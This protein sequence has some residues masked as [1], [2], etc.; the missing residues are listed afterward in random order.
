M[1]AFQEQVFNTKNYR[2][3]IVKDGTVDT[4]RRCNSASE[5]VQRIISGCLTLTQLDYRARHDS[6]AKILHEKLAL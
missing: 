6:V 3:F 2:T 4:C 1:C 5:N